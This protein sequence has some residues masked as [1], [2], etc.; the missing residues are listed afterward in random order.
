MIGKENLN[1][2]YSKNGYIIIRFFIY[3]KGRV[4]TI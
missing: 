1:K 4:K 3:Y 2:E